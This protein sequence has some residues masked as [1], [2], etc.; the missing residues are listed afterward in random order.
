MEKIVLLK[1]NQ[2][3]NLYPNSYSKAIKYDNSQS[4]LNAENV[5]NAIE[6]LYENIQATAWS[7]YVGT[8]NT[9][10]KNTISQNLSNLTY[11]TNTTGL[12]DVDVNTMSYIWFVV[13]AR[14]AVACNNIEVPLSYEGQ[15]SQAGLFYYR[16]EEMIKSSIKVNIVLLSDIQG[17]GSEGG[18]STQ[19]DA[20]TPTVTPKSNSS[21]TYDEGDSI[22]P[23]VVTASSSDRGTLTFQWYNGDK[24]IGTPVPGT[25]DNESYIS[26]YAPTVN[27]HYWCRV[28]NSKTGYN[29]SYADSGEMEIIINSDDETNLEGFTLGK[30]I[31]KNGTLE[32]NENYCI[33]PLYTINGTGITTICVINKLN[34]TNTIG[35][36]EVYQNDGS[37]LVARYDTC[38]GG[39]R[40]NAMGGQKI[41]FVFPYSDTASYKPQEHCFACAI[42]EGTVQIL[43][44]GHKIASMLSLMGD[45]EDYFGKRFN[46]DSE[47]SP[48]PVSLADNLGASGTT[49]NGTWVT[50]AIQLVE[51]HT[52]HIYTGWTSRTPN[53]SKYVVS[54]VEL[55]TSGGNASDWKWAATSNGL[56]YY[57]FAANS[58]Y[59]KFLYCNFAFEQLHNCYVYDATDNVYI[60]KGSNVI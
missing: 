60:I 26:E 5:Q 38:T 22:T 49:Y 56:N 48:Y 57:V 46:V 23:L 8:Y 9:K 27:G 16:T 19:E 34:T 47:T 12:I 58:V 14:I 43:F 37:T 3:N 32:D 55:T 2:G 45:V 36:W 54:Q 20:A 10:S 29:T 51:N 13:N 1:D 41:R 53:Y 44:K 39:R 35:I 42:N 18:S 33:S 17:G 30:R 40:F 52:Y 15:D 11:Y 6:E 21:V 28:F 25:E 7:G 24:K 4:G 59:K 31:L 50:K